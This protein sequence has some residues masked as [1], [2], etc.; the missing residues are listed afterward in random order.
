MNVLLDW[1]SG[2]SSCELYQDQGIKHYYLT[3][4]YS[5]ADTIKATP[6]TIATSALSVGFT[7]EF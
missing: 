4:D 6:V 7:F 5:R 2:D 3:L 1:I